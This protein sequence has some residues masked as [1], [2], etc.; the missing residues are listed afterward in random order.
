MDQ[1][2]LAAI[3]NKKQFDK[4]SEEIS[5]I[6]IATAKF[7]FDV[8]YIPSKKNIIADFLSRNPLWDNKMGQGP[9]ITDDFG[10]TVPI[11]LYRPKS[12]QLRL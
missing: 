1:Q 6:I 9:L 12:M 10:R 11:H 7:N 4:V 5:D 2:A 8:E 3:Y